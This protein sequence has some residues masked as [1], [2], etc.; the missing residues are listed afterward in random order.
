MAKA[1]DRLLQGG[2][3]G[4]DAAQK[5]LNDWVARGVVPPDIAGAMQTAIN[6]AQTK[7]NNSPPIGI[8]TAAPNAGET[9]KEI[10]GIA[11]TPRNAVIGTSA[12]DKEK[13]T[14]EIDGIVKTARTAIIGTSAPTVPTTAGSID[15]IVKTART[16]IIGT[17][18][19]SVPST[20]AQIDGIAY[21]A[22][23]AIIG[24]TAP[25]V[26]N[27][28][29]QIDNAARNRTGT[30]TMNLV[31]TAA[32]I[33]AG[34]PHTPGTTA[35]TAVAATTAA[36]PVMAGASST[37]INITMPSGTTMANTVA[38]IRRYQRLGGDMGGLLDTV[39]AV[40]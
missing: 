7:I 29:S 18:A 38:S 16:A 17:S 35:P 9:G 14:G 10:D 34:L 39:T 20:H 8:P 19:P 5:Q 27:V 33:A 4:I 37:V 13:T 11:N 30:I 40:R 2:Q 36:V 1:Q 28:N 31:G 32:G 26:G 3:A 15:G 12:P 6:A 23:N 24:V 21:T 22:R 25:N